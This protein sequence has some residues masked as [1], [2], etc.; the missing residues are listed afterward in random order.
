MQC[1]IRK[2]LRFAKG[3]KYSACLHISP[4]KH[5][6]YKA[7]TYLARSIKTNHTNLSAGIE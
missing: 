3:I 1:A 5:N 7:K 2:R 6:L 4:K